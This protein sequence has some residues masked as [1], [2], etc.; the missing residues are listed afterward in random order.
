MSSS[1]KYTAGLNNVGS[2]QVSGTPWV[3][4]SLNCISTDEPVKIEFPF[5]TRWILVKNN[6]AVNP[7]NAKIGFSKNGLAGSNYFTIPFAFATSTA[8]RASIISPLEIKVTELY[9]TGSSNVEVI[10][11]LTN[12]PVARVNNLSGTGDIVGNNWSGSVGVG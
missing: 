4:S 3:T 11:G 8:D 2:Y 10:A 1:F 7:E 12:L 6:S 9:I 5:V